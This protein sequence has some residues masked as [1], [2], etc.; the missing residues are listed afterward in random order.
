MSLI[1]RDRAKALGAMRHAITTRPATWTP[2][3][4]LDAVVDSG[5]VVWAS[6]HRGAVD[7]CQRWREWLD[8]APK[9]D[10]AEPWHKF[11]LAMDLLCNDLLDGG[12]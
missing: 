6:N 12:Q 10:D 8:R 11:A 5:A 1:E 3:D 2:D 4:V 7:A 9:S